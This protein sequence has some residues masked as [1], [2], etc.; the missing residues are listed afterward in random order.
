MI[1]NSKLKK[2]SLHPEKYAQLFAS[3]CPQMKII[4]ILCRLLN[5]RI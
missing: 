4:K 5:T 3:E 1:K 2:T